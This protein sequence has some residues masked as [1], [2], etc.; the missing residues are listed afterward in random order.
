MRDTE[1]MFA[2]PEPLDES[3]PE[4]MEEM[5]KLHHDLGWKPADLPGATPEYRDKYEAWLRSQK[6]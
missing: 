2:D 5:F 4:V 3:D 6:A 1:D